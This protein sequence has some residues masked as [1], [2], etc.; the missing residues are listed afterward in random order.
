M[1]LGSTLGSILFTVS[2]SAGKGYMILSPLLQGGLY[3][4]QLFDHY[5]CSGNN[6]LLLSVCQSI[7]IGWIYGKSLRFSRNNI[8]E[9]N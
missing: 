5:V 9:D 4:L 6:L 1:S 2:Q 3:Y 7:A 8:M